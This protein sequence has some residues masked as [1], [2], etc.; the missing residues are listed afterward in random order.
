M[1]PMC[2]ESWLHVLL[3]PRTTNLPGGTRIPG[4]PAVVGRLSTGL[5]FPGTAAT[6]LLVAAL[7]PVEVAEVVQ[8]GR[9]GGA[10]AGVLGGAA[11]AGVDGLFREV[12]D[13]Q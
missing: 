10:V 1:Y 3:S 6:L 12:G 11:G 13:R 7:P 4:G 9:L 5:G 8:R 2:R